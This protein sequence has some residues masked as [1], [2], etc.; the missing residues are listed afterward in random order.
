M[1]SAGLRRSAQG[2]IATDHRFPWKRPV[3]WWEI[4]NFLHH[5]RIVQ[6]EAPNLWAVLLQNAVVLELRVGTS[7]GRGGETR[8]FLHQWQIVPRLTPTVPQLLI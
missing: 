2:H 1:L 7:H 5:S 8:I 4:P 6:R 3:V